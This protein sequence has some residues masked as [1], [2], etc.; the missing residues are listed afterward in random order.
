[1]AIDIAK[2]RSATA[3][4]SAAKA[5][6]N[7]KP[8]FD[9]AAKT[10]THGGAS[11][12]YPSKYTAK[13]GQAN[14]GGHSKFKGGAKNPFQNKKFAKPGQETAVNADGSAAVAGANPF[15]KQ[16][17]NK[18]KKEKKELKL[19]RKQGDNKDLFE[20]TIEGKKVYEELRW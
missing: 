13:P 17:W 16:D 19:K 3:S 7:K 18:F 9:P 4:P 11:S 15:E 8:K 12:K 20:L 1:M 5:S 10:K 14:G 6:P 2:K